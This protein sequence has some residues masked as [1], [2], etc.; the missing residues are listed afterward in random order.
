M[1][2]VLYGVE[3]AFKQGAFALKGTAQLDRAEAGTWWLF[4]SRVEDAAGLDIYKTTVKAR[5]SLKSYLDSPA[6]SAE[7]RVMAYAV[8]GA[9]VTL[10][11]SCGI[12]AAYTFAD[13]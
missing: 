4:L 1:A 7:A 11:R 13:A 3:Q 9:M 5:D 6:G 2:D 12:D 10:A 8:R